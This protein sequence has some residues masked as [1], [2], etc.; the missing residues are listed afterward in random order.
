MKITKTYFDAAKDFTLPSIVSSI[1]QGGI[2]IA[3]GGSLASFVCPTE[4][5]INGNLVSLPSALNIC[6]F[7]PDATK[8]EVIYFQMLFN[9]FIASSINST[10]LDANI[11]PKSTV[12]SKNESLCGISMSSIK[13]GIGYGWHSIFTSDCN[14]EMKCEKLTIPPDDVGPDNSYTPEDDIHTKIQDSFDLLRRHG[15]ITGINMVI[16]Q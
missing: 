4:I 10:I 3:A 5:T 13:E 7:I 15:I 14:L 6:Y 1:S 9:N 8:R 11:V 16:T 12:F 2:Q